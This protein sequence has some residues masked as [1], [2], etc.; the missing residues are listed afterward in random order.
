[1]VMR[2]F[3]LDMS[4]AKIAVVL[5]LMLLSLNAQSQ[6]IGEI[7]GH[8]DLKYAQVALSVR[9]IET[10]ELVHHH[11]GDVLLIPAS[12]L[13]VITTFTTL[14]AFGEDFK[15]RTTLGYRGDILSDGTLD[16][17]LIIIGSG[18]PSLASPDEE[19]LS[20]EDLLKDI[21]RVLKSSGISCI[22]GG[23]VV[24]DSI[25]DSEGIHH[26][27][28]WDDLTNYY[29]SGAYG[30]NFRE[31]YYDVKFRSSS[32][33]GELTEIVSISPDIGLSSLENRVVS[34]AKGSG[35]NAYIYG[36][37]Y[38]Y[39][40]YVK[41]SIPPGRSSFKIYGAIPNPARTFAELLSH[42][43]RTQEIKVDGAAVI[44]LEEPY[45]LTAY[46]SPELGQLVKRANF[47]SNNL[48]CEAFLKKIGA[49]DKTS[50]VDF[51]DGVEAVYK[52][53]DHI[54]V[55]QSG[56]TMM[57]GSGLSLKNRISTNFFTRFLATIANRESVNHITQ[58]LPRTGQ[59]DTT[60]ERF[61]T[62]NASYG[63][64]WLK[65]G[66]LGGVLS[67]TGVIETQSGNWMSI[68]LISNGHTVGNSR[69]RK[70][71]AQI[72]DEVYRIN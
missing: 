67:Y 9:S 58:Y 24:D 39:D 57:D 5:V 30:F 70:H 37:P 62:D 14:S 68:S 56:L 63:H 23:I 65:S 41:G 28:P 2:C 49:R 54:G 13:K 52:Y 35:D 64:V 11:N 25:Y 71:F 40:R 18:D 38:G 17:D 61:M 66:S 53:L 46:Q 4:M 60:L 50:G 72:I 44:G 29:A 32:T 7:L 19:V 20:L 33:P 69:I 48:Y 47:E 26:T 3:I 15:Y 1:M 16:G 10:G 42:H 43:L 22:A 21:S 31:N 59:K 27:W 12:S 36:D 34:G 51:E 45:I 55:G 8:E 6:K